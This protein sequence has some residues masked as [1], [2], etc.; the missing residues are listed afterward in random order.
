LKK[1]LDFVPLNSKVQIKNLL[2]NKEIIFLIKEKRKTKHGDFRIME[3]NK[4]QITLNRTKNKYQFIITLLHEIAHYDTY[5]SHGYNVKPHGIEWKNNF[6]LLML[7]F[8]NTDIFPNEI[9]KNLSNYIRNPKASTENDFNLIMSLKKYDFNCSSN[10]VFELKEGDVFKIENGKKYKF[11]RK[12]N[13]RCECE[14]FESGRKYL[15]SPQ[16][17]IE[18]I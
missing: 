1:L 3:D 12:K 2:D 16:V 11:I 10:F 8:L 6:R 7:P 4:A 17:I 13:K 9:L 14:E 5:L 18:L 15:F